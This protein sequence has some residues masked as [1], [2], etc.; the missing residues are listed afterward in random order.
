MTGNFWAVKCAN[1]HSQF[2]DAGDTAAALS[3]DG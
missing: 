2:R 3:Q 1:E